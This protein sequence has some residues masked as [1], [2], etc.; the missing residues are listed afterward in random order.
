MAK[1]T[2]K[3]AYQLFHE[4]IIALEEIESNGILIDMQYVKDHQKII[5]DKLKTIEESILNSEVGI[6]WKKRYGDKTSVIS[7]TQLCH[8]LY[9]YL[10]LWPVGISRKEK[11]KT[12]KEWLSKV[13]H[14][15]CKQILEYKKWQKVES[16]YLRPLTVETDENNMV[17]PSFNLNLIDSYRSGCSNVNMQNQSIRVSST[18]KI[19]R[20]C[21][22]PPKGYRLIEID[23]S[24]LEIRGACCVHHDSTLIKYVTENFDMHSKFA[25]L[26]FI[27]SEQMW[28]LLGKNYSKFQKMMRFAGKSG[29]SFSLQYGNFYAQIAMNLWRM[30]DDLNLQVSPDETLKQ[31]LVK[32]MKGS[33]LER[34]VRMKYKSLPSDID[35]EIKE[36]YEKDCAF[37]KNYTDIDCSKGI[38]VLSEMDRAL[39]CYFHH[40]EDCERFYYEKEFPEFNQ[41]KKDFYNQYMEDGFFYNLTGFK[42]S[43]VLS[44]NQVLN[45][46]VQSISF[47]CLLWALTE[48]QKELKKRGLKTKIFT[49]IHDSIVLYVPVEEVDEVCELCIDYMTTKTRERFPWICVPLEAEIDI[50]PVDYSWYYKTGKDKYDIFLKLLKTGCIEEAKEFNSKELKYDESIIDDIIEKELKYM[51]KG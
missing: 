26:V 29:F 44:K 41:W 18:A 50:C 21:F 34:R 15:I 5:N 27:I 40:I 45:Y 22:I 31:Y 8:I 30:I 1:A 32:T 10:K 36:K 28:D 47:H 35:D 24:Q 48:I 16:T 4:G 46:P 20:G 38:D 19:I 33:S 7:N 9:D 13:D 49:E 23:Q 12:D 6:Y 14:P 39:V 2:L 43:G 51:E 37:I 42:F 17:H 3:D 25:R 11:Q